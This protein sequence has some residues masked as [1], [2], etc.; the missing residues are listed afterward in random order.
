MEAA[1][2]ASSALAPKGLREKIKPILNR[3]V[4]ELDS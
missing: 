3:A 1:L 2:L 4:V